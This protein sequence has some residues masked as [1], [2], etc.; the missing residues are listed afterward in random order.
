MKKIAFLLVLTLI[1]ILGACNK[2]ENNSSTQ[3]S[4]TDGEAKNAYGAIDHGVEDKGIGFNLSGNTIEEATGVPQEEKE[5]IL[6]VFNAYIDTFNEQDIEGY[7]ETLSDRTESFD[8]EE[9]RKGLTEAFNQNELKRQV[10]DVTI[11]KYDEEKAQ[12]FANLETT[13]KQK[14][15]GL[16]TSPSGRQV[17][18]LTKDDGKWKISAVHYMGNDEN[19]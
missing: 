1:L 11:V 6:R 19:K 9:E 14:S 3:G 2:E 4:A 17:T 15:T 13:M 5:Q 16:K 8:K 10:S 7:I 12:V 18:V